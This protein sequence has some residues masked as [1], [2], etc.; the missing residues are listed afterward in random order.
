MTD[1]FPYTTLGERDFL[2]EMVL[3]VGE[4]SLVTAS[5][6]ET[7]TVLR[8]DAPA[9]NALFQNLPRFALN[10]STNAANSSAR[11]LVRQHPSQ[12]EG[13]GGSPSGPK[14]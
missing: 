12:M 4:K 5:V 14:I 1:R 6:V 2:C 8:I 9:I 3:L 7:T 10:S 11:Q 13:R